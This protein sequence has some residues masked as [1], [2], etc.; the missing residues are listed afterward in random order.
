LI[1]YEKYIAMC[2]I[3]PVEAW[4]DLRRGV[5]ILDSHYLSNNKNR[6]SSLPNVLTYPQSEF[7]TNSVHIP[8]PLRNTTSIFT[9]KLFWQP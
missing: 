1:I 3:D 9:E 6:A 7:T 5:L 4:S 8:T 2:G